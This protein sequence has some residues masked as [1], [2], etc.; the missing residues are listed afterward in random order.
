MMIAKLLLC[1]SSLAEEHNLDLDDSIRHL[2]ENWFSN[3]LD[4]EN[5]FDAFIGLY[6]MINVI[7]GNRP[8][9][10]PLPYQI[11]KI[12]GWMFGQ[13]GPLKV[14]LLGRSSE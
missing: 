4:D 9:V 2:V 13:E 8:A 1:S 5:R 7:L 10:E 11:S 14:T 6:G 12:E 3:L